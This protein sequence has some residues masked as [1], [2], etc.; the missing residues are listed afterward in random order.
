MLT[1]DLVRGI[2]AGVPFVLRPDR[3]FKLE[4]VS[5]GSWVEA[6]VREHQLTPNIVH[7]GRFNFW[8]CSPSDVVSHYISPAKQRCMH[9]RQGRCC[10]RPP[11]E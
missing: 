11:R 9:Q 4:D 5:M 6:V 2:A 10:N 7:S 3:L 8:G 1:V